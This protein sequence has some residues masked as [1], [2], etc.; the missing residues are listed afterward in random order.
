MTAQTSGTRRASPPAFKSIEEEL[1]FV[2][3]EK[4]FVQN[5][6]TDLLG[7]IETQ[8]EPE[9]RVKLI[10]ACGRG[11]FNRHSFKQEIAR[12]GQG[13]VENLIAAYKHNFEIWQA[14]DGVHIRYGE[15]S[16]GCY[17]PAAYYRPEEPDDLHCECTRTT[18]QTIWETALDRPFE[19]EILEAVRR[20]GQTC[21][22]LVK[23]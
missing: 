22:F 23:V 14:A 17:C 4:E 18:H 3:Q 8:L 9:Q 12:Q 13:S 20:G 1:A 15:K 7:G 21:H 6:L 16:R 11:C 10:E 5:W 19:V 2:K